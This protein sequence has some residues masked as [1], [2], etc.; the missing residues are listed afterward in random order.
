M[1]AEKLKLQAKGLG[2]E[3]SILNHLASAMQA[4]ATNFNPQTC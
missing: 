2:R 3:Q 1:N 4:A